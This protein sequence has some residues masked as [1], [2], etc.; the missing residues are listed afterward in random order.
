MRCMLQREGSESAKTP[1]G[2]LDLH[3]LKPHQL[4]RWHSSRVTAEQAYGWACWDDG[5]EKW[6]LRP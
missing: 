5:Q 1:R 3:L 2:A 6:A 4:V